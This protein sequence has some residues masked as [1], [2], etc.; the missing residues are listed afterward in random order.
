MKGKRER[1]CVC[2][3]GEGEKGERT[4]EKICEKAELKEGVESPTKA[5]GRS[6]RHSNT[7]ICSLTCTPYVPILFTSPAH[8]TESMTAQ[9]D[10][11]FSR[12][13][14][15]VLIREGFVTMATSL[16]CGWPEAR[17]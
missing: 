16:W 1:V 9:L 13:F 5:K 11:H 6:Q 3:K 14:W 12:H 4:R 8:H 17:R 7:H 10:R 15:L 2:V